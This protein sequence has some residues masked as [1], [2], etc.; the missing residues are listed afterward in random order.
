MPFESVQ[1]H[2]KY[3]VEDMLCGTNEGIVYIQIKSPT[4]FHRLQFT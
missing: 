3:Q 2:N 4:Y 1:A